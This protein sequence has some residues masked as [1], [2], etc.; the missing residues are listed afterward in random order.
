MRARWSFPLAHAILLL[1]SFAF[2][3]HGEEPSTY[4]NP[5]NI[6]YGYCPIPDFVKNGKHRTTADLSLFDFAM[7]T[8]CSPPINGATGGVPIC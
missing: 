2:F 4:C 1:T 8:I 6:D 7:T 3:S 5:I